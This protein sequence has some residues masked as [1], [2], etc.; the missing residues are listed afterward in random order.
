MK[1]V[2]LAFL[3]SIS[4]ANSAQAAVDSCL[5]GTW[6][7]DISDLADL[8]TLQMGNRAS[9]LG[10]DARMDIAADGAMR[11]TAREMQV[12]V[13]MPD[14]PEVVVTVDGY[15]AGSIDATDGVWIT[16]VPEYNLT[17]TA[18]VLGQ[19]MSIPF[20]SATGMFGGGLGSYRC[21]ATQLIFESDPTGPARIPRTWQRG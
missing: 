20:T 14:I 15:S 16:T 8:M 13:A 19:P 3:G 10:G 2:V 18:D 9:A 6:W 12:S 4:L 21:N 7:A 5:V 1:P 17:G 11:I